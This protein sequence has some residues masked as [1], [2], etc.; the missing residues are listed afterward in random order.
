MPTPTPRIRSLAKLGTPHGRRIQIARRPQRR[1]LQADC[2]RVAAEI[3]KSPVSPTQIQGGQSYT[4][5]VN[6]GQAFNV[7]QFRSSK[8]DIKLVEHAKQTYRDFVPNC[9]Y[10]GMLGDV[11]VYIWDLVPGPAFCRVRFSASAW[12]NKPLR[13]TSGSVEEY[14]RTLD[15][16][17]HG[18]PGR[19][20]WKLDDV[21]QGLPLIFRPEYP[22]AVQ[23][24]DFLEN[25]FHVN[26]ATGHITG[27]VDWADAIFAPFGLSLSGLETILSL[28]AHFWDTFYGEIVARLFGLFQTYGFEEGDARIAYLEALCML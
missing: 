23:H 20:R 17:S 3:L 12:I 25:N 13:R 16:I 9:K 11:Y 1:Y 22:K 7:V 8:L 5:T 6:S 15:Q 27:V 24:D 28:R 26:E 21:R 10:F 19:I 18:L 4:V 2:D 14:S